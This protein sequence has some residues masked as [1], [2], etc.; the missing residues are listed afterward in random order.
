MLFCSIGNLLA[1][2]FEGDSV[3]TVLLSALG[4]PTFLCVLGS[5]MFFNLKEAA[6]H[7]VNVGTNWSSYSRSAIRFD[8]LEQLPEYVTVP[9]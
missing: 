2:K 6:E 8:E 7:G 9:F 5:R 3:V 4:S 1:T